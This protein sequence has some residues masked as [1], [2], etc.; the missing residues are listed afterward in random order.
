[1]TSATPTA[2][3]ANGVAVSASTAD[4]MKGLG[5][6]ATA[7]SKATAIPRRRW[8]PEIAW[9][10]ELPGMSGVGKIHADTG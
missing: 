4:G 8:P 10:T 7:G 9:R 6:M 3:G 5:D 2:G 1:V